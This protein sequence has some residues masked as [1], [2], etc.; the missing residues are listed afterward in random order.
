MSRANGVDVVVDAIDDTNRAPTP[1]GK[2][3]TVRSHT[4]PQPPID[5]TDRPI[6]WV[7]TAERAVMTP[8]LRTHTAL[9]PVLNA[10]EK[11]SP[12]FIYFLQFCLVTYA[13]II[14]GIF[15]MFAANR[16][17]GNT[18]WEGIFGTASFSMNILL[19]LYFGQRM[20]SFF[21][22]LLK[23]APG[24]EI[25]CGEK[26]LL[27]ASFFLATL[28]TAS[29]VAVS[30]SAVHSYITNITFVRFLVA[31]FCINT[32]STRFVGSYQ[33]LRRLFRLESA[34]QD[35]RSDRE[36]KIVKYL[37]LLF[38]TVSTIMVPLWAGL[39]EKGILAVDSDTP[40]L[41]LAIST[42][43]AS[44]TNPLFY[45]DS[46]FLVPKNLALAG[47]NLHALVHNENYRR[48]T[49]ALTAIL[50]VG[51]L[52]LG[53][54]SG[55]GFAEVMLKMLTQGSFGQVIE[56]TH[57]AR[58]MITAY[59][60]IYA[61]HVTM[62]ITGLVNMNGTA[63][64]FNKVIDVKNRDHIALWYATLVYLGFAGR[65]NALERASSRVTIAAMMELRRNSTPLER[66][67]GCLD[68]FA[69][70]FKFGRRSGYQP[71]SRVEDLEEG[72][73]IDAATFQ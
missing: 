59:R 67:P 64:F 29:G 45:A 23:P 9:G 4:S 46:T 69:A 42:W 37:G 57:V 19:A 24:A 44:V 32:F 16:A 25:S 33:L 14:S 2:R 30:H 62:V 40:W 21:K 12:Y 13:S 54:I 73:S 53:I 50:G 56:S 51:F 58:E 48:L 20:E 65:G 68:N 26:G 61:H 5:L 18:L 55:G 39:T 7:E 71:V 49:N 52:T 36:K 27:L 34:D 38:A 66:Q 60:A 3:V 8:H 31:L 10:L 15:S 43:A 70:K 17:N 35:N 11:A 22:S 72:R 6:P 63:A 28:T 47:K 1:G 41:A